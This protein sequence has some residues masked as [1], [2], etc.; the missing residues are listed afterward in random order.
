MT[1]PDPLTHRALQARASLREATDERPVPSLRPPGVRTSRPAFRWALPVLAAVAVLAV[2]FAGFWGG[3]RTPHRVVA[4]GAVTSVP[5]GQLPVA[6]VTDGQLVWI[7]DSGSDRVIALDAHTLRRRW[8]TRVGSRPVAL[9]N[10]LGGVWVVLADSDRLLKLDPRSGRVLRSG[11]ASL[12]PVAVDIAFGAVW[13]LSAGNQTLDRYDPTTVAQTGS[14]VLGA[15]GRDVAHSLD[16]LWVTVPGGLR[17]VSPTSTGLPVTSFALAGQPRVAVAGGDRNLWVVL[18]NGG[19]VTVDSTTGAV[20]R[21]LALSGPATA[22]APIGNGVVAVT[23]DGQLQRFDSPDASGVL[24]AS[25]GVPADA[26]A[27]HG[28]TLVGTARRTALLYATELAR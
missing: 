22:L 26:L 6:V 4:A 17:R 18:A 10:G 3:S 13:V 16:A 23:A 2:V 20:H 5:A 9:A 12:D 1:E 27:I 24:I 28:R 7:A 21:R 15:A 25:T 14:A 19:L 8:T 11:R